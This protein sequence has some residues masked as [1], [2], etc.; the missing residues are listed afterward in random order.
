MCII[1]ATKMKCCP[2][3]SWWIL[4]M[5]VI[6]MFPP[7]AGGCREE[8]RRALLD[9][10]FSLINTYDLKPED[11]LPTWMD[12]GNTLVGECCDWERVKCNTTTH[13][14]THISLGTLNGRSYVDKKLWPLN[15]SLFLHFKELRSLN[16]SRNFLDGGIMN[17][18]TLMLN[19]TLSIISTYVKMFLWNWYYMFNQ[20]IWVNLN[21]REQ[22]HPINFWA[23][24]SLRVGYY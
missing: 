18:G 24:R 20:H 7:T 19:C 1:A 8:E 10:K 13:H 3:H 4:M 14:V 12:Y 5:V 22:H 9:I 6:V 11:I 15:V 2:L 16:L 21:S 23:Q 17:T